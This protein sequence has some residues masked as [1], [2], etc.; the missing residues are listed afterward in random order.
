M[1]C[2]VDKVYKNSKDKNQ[3]INKQEKICLHCSLHDDGERTPFKPDEKFENDKIPVD[4]N[5]ALLTI[6]N[7]NLG[8]RYTSFN[9]LTT[10]LDN[11]KWKGVQCKHAGMIDY[12]S[13]F[14]EYEEDDI[15]SEITYKNRF[16][17]FK[18]ETFK[19]WQYPATE[20][21]RKEIINDL[22]EKIRVHKCSKY[23]A[24]CKDCRK[25]GNQITR[26]QKTWTNGHY[27]VRHRFAA[28]C[29]GLIYGV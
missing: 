19:A 6:D 5:A 17:K 23:D 4:D 29:P 15:L 26:H 18:R 24:Y 28:T 22:K 21:E 27:T 8:K 16:E 1:E 12:E 2:V 25:W 9:K 20:Q 3:R 7:L 10:K 13:V 11:H 14:F